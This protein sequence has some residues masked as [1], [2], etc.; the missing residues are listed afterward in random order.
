MGELTD[1]LRV[2]RLY[3]EQAGQLRR[4]WGKRPLLPGPERLGV[5]QRVPFPPVTAAQLADSMYRAIERIPLVLP[6]MRGVRTGGRTLVR[7]VQLFRDR[8]QQLSMVVFQQVVAGYSRRDQA[9]SF[10]AVLE[11]ARQQQVALQQ[12][13]RLSELRVSR[14]RQL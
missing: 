7:C 11:L 10:L 1:R 4:Q 5:Y 9:L 8:L 3:R 13:R 2:Y 12:H 14:T 6:P